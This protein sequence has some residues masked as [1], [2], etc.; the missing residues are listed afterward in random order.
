MTASSSV[1][2]LFPKKDC[3]ISTFSKV[4]AIVA[5]LCVQNGKCAAVDALVWCIRQTGH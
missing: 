3:K 2:K 1:Y 4:Y 5:V